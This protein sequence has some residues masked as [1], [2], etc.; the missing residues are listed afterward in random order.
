LRKRR[1]FFFLAAILLGG[2]IGIGY[3]WWLRPL[4][5]SQADLSN[6]RVDYRTDFV[7]MTAEIFH[8]ENNLAEA[9]LCLQQIDSGSPEQTVQKAVI[10]GGQ[11]GYGQADLQLLADLLQA[12]SSGEMTPAPGESPQP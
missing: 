8:Q 11:L 5:Y 2:L 10:S 6:L 4:M 1:T 12:L 3:G 9:R 7:L